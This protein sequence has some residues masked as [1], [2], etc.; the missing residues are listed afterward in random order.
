MGSMSPRHELQE[1]Q[2]PLWAMPTMGLNPTLR[3]EKGKE[4]QIRLSCVKSVRPIR[5]KLSEN[6]KVIF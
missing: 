2:V 4:I 1:V 6:Q 5:E 3:Q